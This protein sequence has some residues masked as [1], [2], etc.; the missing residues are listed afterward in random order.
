MGRTLRWIASVS[1]A[2]LLAGC[3]QSSTG[4]RVDRGSF[5][6]ETAHQA[7][8]ADQR[9]RFLV[10]HYTAEDFH[11]SLN[12]LTDE[13]VSAHYLIPAHPPKAGGKPVAWQLVPESQRAWHAGASSWRGRSNLNDTSI[14]IELENR[15][16]RST[17]VGPRWYPFPPEQ[18][19]LL[20]DISHQVIESYQIAPQNVLGHS[21]IAPQRKQD[22][23]PLFPWH[24]LALAGIGAW[25]DAS[26]VTFYLAGREATEPVDRLQLLEKLA[27]Y[28]Y[29]LPTD[30][31]PTELTPEQQQRVIAAFQMHF[32]PSDYRG[33][34]DAESEAIVLALL[35]KYGSRD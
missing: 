20:A 32:R 9:I 12:T 2:L 31:L 22:P 18:I 1:L 15:G 7:Q 13:H 23:G 10:I 30:P 21:D 35:E 3:Q 19:A 33:Q 5:M 28:G 24:K 17:L 16:Y 26:R 14:G 4:S 34:A 8:A 11:S 29:S 27:Q 6:L 25:P